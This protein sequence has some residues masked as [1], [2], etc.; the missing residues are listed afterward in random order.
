[1]R[2]REVK[3]SCVC[4]KVACERW[5]VTKWCV[6]DGV[7]K[8]V[9]DKVVCERWCGKRWCVTKLCVKD[10][11]W[12]SGV[13]KMVCDKVGCERWWVTKWCVKDGVWQRW[14]TESKTRTPHKDLGNK[15]YPNDIAT[16]NYCRWWT[17]RNKNQSVA[18]SRCVKIQMVHQCHQCEERRSKSKLCP[19]P[20]FISGTCNYRI[21]S[22]NGVWLAPSISWA[23]KA[24]V[25][26]MALEECPPIA[27]ETAVSQDIWRIAMAHWGS[28][29]SPAGTKDSDAQGDHTERPWRQKWDGG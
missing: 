26:R 19:V 8:M 4:D 2:D 23:I 20:T 25:S 6:K 24:I 28:S 22:P 21:L 7:S 11:G 1:M 17:E 3:Q 18:V 12:Q 29:T 14:D 15:R 13:W 10:G 16:K 9:C 27:V 5:C